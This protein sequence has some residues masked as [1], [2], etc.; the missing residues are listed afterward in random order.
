MKK[1]SDRDAH[2][3]E[4]QKEKPG[5]KA[6][7][8]EDAAPDVDVDLSQMN[9][10][11]T[12]LEQQEQTFSGLPRDYKQDTAL[13]PKTQFIKQIVLEA[14]A[15]KEQV[16]IFTHSR[17]VL[18]HMQ[19][20]LRDWNK[21]IRISRLDGSTSVNDRTALAKDFN[22]GKYDLMLISTRAG[23]LGLNLHGASRV[24][25]NDFGFNPSWEEQAVGRA[26]RLGQQKPVFVYHLL[27][28]GTFEEPLHQRTV[29]KKQ[30][31]HR[32]VDKK[33]SKPVANK[34]HEFL[35]VPHSQEQ[36]D[37]E[38]SKG[39]DTALDHVL[40]SEQDFRIRSIQTT[41]IF[42]QA[43]TELTK[44]E[45]QE[46]K[47]ELEMWRAKQAGDQTK[48][49]ELKKAQHNELLRQ[50]Y[51]M[52]GY[53]QNAPGVMATPGAGPRTATSAALPASATTQ[54][55][56]MNATA[57]GT[58]AAPTGVVAPTAMMTPAAPAKAA[59]S[60]TE[61]AQSGTMAPTAVMTPAVA[62]QIA[63]SGEE[64]APTRENTAP[65]GAMAPTAIKTPPAATDPT[66]HVTET[67][68]P[69]RQTATVDLTADDEAPT[70]T[71]AGNED[72]QSGLRNQSV[73]PPLKRVT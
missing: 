48:V 20:W 47:R 67:T 7:P 25:L 40:D 6:T 11:S 39:I 26:Y 8:P 32:A 3:R 62:S 61:V 18:D 44:E 57:S 43:D 63:T 24:I 55:A 52:L 41:D 71:V 70:A 33:N 72:D 59:P 64:A 34:M 28:G 16:L 1:L 58:E 66:S 15:A 23:G 2:R 31:S 49:E 9:L 35:F 54:A 50:Q 4:T 14:K 68:T 29:F 13:S 45:M 36:E 51:E 12:M 19:Q 42:H 22:S 17:P 73:T 65:T 5:K 37:L 46:V 38:A 60:E 27:C 10:S 30:L 56:P 53:P 69:G 21:D